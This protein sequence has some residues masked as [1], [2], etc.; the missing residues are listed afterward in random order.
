MIKISN[1][2]NFFIFNAVVTSFA[3]IP[4]AASATCVAA[5]VIF[6]A[7]FGTILVFYPRVQA[8]LF[9]SSSRDTQQ[10]H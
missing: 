3:V 5:G 2:V 9:P 6:G 4:G 8:V 10:D 7:G 1:P